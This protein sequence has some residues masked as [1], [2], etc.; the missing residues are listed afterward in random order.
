MKVFG[1]AFWLEIIGGLVR[2]AKRFPLSILSGLLCATSLSVLVDSSIQG[3][4]LWQERWIR[5]GF[6]GG[7]GISFFTLLELIRERVGGRT[8]IKGIV[9]TALAFLFLFI[10]YRWIPID[11]GENI[12]QVLLIRFATFVAVVHLAIAVIPFWSVKD[13]DMGLWEYNKLLF[14]RFLLTGFFSGILFV[15]IALALASIDQLFG[16]DIDEENYPRVCFFC[17]F[18]LNPCLFLGGFPAQDEILDFQLDFPIWILFLSKFILLPL[19]ILYFCILYAYTGKIV[20]NWTWPDGMVGLPVF[21]LSAV[22][23][24]TGLLVWPLSRNPSTATWAKRFWRLFF[25]LFVPLSI[26]LLLSLQ[27][28]ISDYGFTEIRFLGVLLSIWVLG[29]SAYFSV[30]PASSFK[31]IPWSLL[32]LFFVTAVGPISPASIARKSQWNRLTAFL[33]E[34]EL[35]KDGTLVS[36]P[37][38]V[39]AAEYKDILSMV[40][41]LRKGY[42]PGDFEPLIRGISAEDRKDEHG[43]DWLDLNPWD[44]R[45]MFLDYTGIISKELP[46]RTSLN[47]KLNP[48]DPISVPQFTDIYTH[49]K[50]ASPDKILI[51]FNVHEESVQLLH[52]TDPYRLK[53]QDS[54]GQVLAT[55][56][57]DA[58]ATSIGPQDL[59]L[60]EGPYPSMGR[61]FLS[62]D[63]DLVSLGKIEVVFLD[64][65]LRKR[66]DVWRVQNGNF[67]IL[68]PR[69]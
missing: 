59:M 26:L 25:P 55:L 43:I 34:K 8:S 17:A 16:V 4:E 22:G 19:V 36:H 46:D 18:V 54:V 21:I 6:T 29:I 40:E 33:N 63:V 50:Y 1:L 39:D 60:G 3:N 64:I 23:G 14:S 42:G 57:L 49:Q 69:S 5:L 30:K 48:N 66:N 45:K 52:G 68:V 31:V 56:D 38:E 61:E 27:R 67:W 15:G 24:L 65:S 7:F 53:F 2:V 62:F 13:S 9:V 32:G 12:H 58:W 35:I 44:F 28:R 10:F 51:T 41:Y 47:I 37:Q 20:L 11:Y